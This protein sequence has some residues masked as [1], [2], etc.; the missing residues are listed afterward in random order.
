MFCLVYI[1]LVCII[2]MNVCFLLLFF[3]GGLFFRSKVHI[4]S[5]KR[6][7]K[8]GYFCSYLFKASFLFPY[9]FSSGL[10]TA[11]WFGDEGLRGSVAFLFSIVYNQMEFWVM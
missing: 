10:M 6:D 7:A 4:R 2:D 9:L 5:R 8:K 11:A 1:C 3:L